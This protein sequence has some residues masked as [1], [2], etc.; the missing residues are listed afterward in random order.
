MTTATNT[1]TCTVCGDQNLTFEA[2][3]KFDLITCEFKLHRKL[4]WMPRC[5]TCK[6]DVAW[7]WQD[8]KP[9]DRPVR[10]AAGNLL[11]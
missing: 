6:R 10:N 3:A 4:D 5:S 9:I 8:I 2:T 1:P 11:L 7:S